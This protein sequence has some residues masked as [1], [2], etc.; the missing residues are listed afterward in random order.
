M[1]NGEPFSGD[2]EDRFDEERI[3]FAYDQL[4]PSAQE[5][6][7]D[8]CSFFYGWH[9]DWEEVACIVG[10]VEIECLEEGALIKRKKEISGEGKL[11]TKI[12]IHDLLLSVGCNK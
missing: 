7:L 10:N 6:S 8:I 4:E 5:A 3:M 2:R 9:W 1:E 12:S 11:V